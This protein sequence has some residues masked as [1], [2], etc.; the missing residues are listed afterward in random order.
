MLT[1]CVFERFCVYPQ[2]IIIQLQKQ[3]RIRKIQLLSHQFL[4]GLLTLI[5]FVYIFI[6]DIYYLWAAVLRIG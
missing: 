6:L 1:C 4:I 3:T 5:H 2:D